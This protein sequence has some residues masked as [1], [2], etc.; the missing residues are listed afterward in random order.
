MKKLQV[1]FHNWKHYTQ[2]IPSMVDIVY[3]RNFDLEEKRMEFIGLFG[4]RE[5]LTT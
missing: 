1:V 2:P 3:L 4:R 5:L